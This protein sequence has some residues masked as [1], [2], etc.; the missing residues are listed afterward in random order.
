MSLIIRKAKFEDAVTVQ[1]LRNTGWQDNYQYPK[2]GVSLDFLKNKL[3]VLPPTEEDIK[4]F[5]D[6]LD[7]TMQNT[8]VAIVDDKV[9][10]VIFCE[11]VSENWCDIGVFVARKYRGR[12]IG[13]KLL[14][15][16][17]ENSKNNL[18]VDI[19]AKNLSKKL[20]KAVGFIE[21]GKEYEYH[22]DKKTYLPVQ[23][24]VY[25][26]PKNVNFGL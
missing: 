20:Y 25:I 17:I 6:R 1:E 15:T 13:K 8:F 2:G 18:Q 7:N 21:S 26:N 19:F 11:D 12:G 24:L 14:L 3:A 10:G 5:L 23:K 16:L 9:I 22:F 4:Y